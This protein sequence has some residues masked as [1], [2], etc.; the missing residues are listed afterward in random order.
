MNNEPDLKKTK[1]GL[2]KTK[3]LIERI[4]FDIVKREMTEKERRILLAKPK[5]SSKRN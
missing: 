4:F 3:I 1:M 5:K 2:H